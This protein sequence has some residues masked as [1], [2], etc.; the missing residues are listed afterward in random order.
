MTGVPADAPPMSAAPAPLY[1]RLAGEI[2]GPFALAQLR[3]LVD[4]GAATPDTASAADPAGP[5]APLKTLPVAATLFPPPPAFRFKAAEFE[6]RNRDTSAPLDVQGF[7]AAANLPPPASAPA[8]AVPPPSAAP[9]PPNEVEQMVH[10]VA[11]RTA[12]HTPPEQAAPFARRHRRSL[13][14]VRNFLVVAVTGDAI[15]AALALA[16]G[17]LDDGQ[18]LQIWIGWG[19]L[20]TVAAAV[21]ALLLETGR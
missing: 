13:R 8:A 20:F 14:Q 5:W 9:T 21:L 17:R 7:I 19:C 16:Y 4:G 6:I 12:A 15:L 2:R 10:A 18:S 3:A 1:L 11:A